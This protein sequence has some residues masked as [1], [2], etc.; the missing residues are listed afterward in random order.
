MGNYVRTAILLAAMTAIF[1]GAGFLLGGQ[2]GMLIALAAAAAMNLFAWWNS[3]ATV[4]RYYRAKEVSDRSHSLYRIVEQLADRDGMPMPK[5]YIIDNPQPNAFATGRSPE[6]ASVAAT[7][8]LLQLMNEREVAGVMAHE[9][10]HVKNR[11]TLIMTVTATLAGAISML[12]NF[13]LFFGGSRNNPLGIVGV[14]AMMILAPLAAMLVQMAIS[15]T[16][17]YEADAGGAAICGNP[18]WLADALEKLEVGSKRIDNQAAEH[19]PATAH[20]FIVNPL[21]AHKHDSLF[22]THPATANRVARLR[23]MTGNADEAAPTPGEP[24]SGERNPRAVRGSVPGAGSRRGARGG[25]W[26]R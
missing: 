15:R 19:N 14:L 17:E 12:A 11:D 26:G 23:A 24:W 22:S 25:P 7:T 18:D 13:A 2:T 3:G 10:A 21:H 1:M 16:R 5:V 8:G 4:L 9:L 20:M 6:N